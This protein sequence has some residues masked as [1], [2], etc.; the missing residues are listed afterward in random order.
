MRWVTLVVAIAACGRI[1][2][3]PLPSTGGTSG[4]RLRIVAW[5]F[6]DGGRIAHAVYDAERGER[7]AIASWDDGVIRCTPSSLALVEYLD[8]AC[9]Q[10]VAQVIDSACG[11]ATY[12]ETV[13]S[14]GTL[15]G[16]YALGSATAATAFYELSNGTC[17]GP[18]AT[19]AGTLLRS[20]SRRK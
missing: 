7:C 14:A 10:P 19:T 6:A 1:G 20:N 15:D 3:D 18:N 5:Q 12:V 8:A 11:S 9:T 17:A 2:F 16:L 13:G 4:S